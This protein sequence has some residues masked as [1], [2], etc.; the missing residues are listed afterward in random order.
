MQSLENI[1]FKLLKREMLLNT[2]AILIEQLQ[3]LNITLRKYDAI[4]E[5][6]IYMN[7]FIFEKEFI[8][9]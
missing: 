5:Y 7:S 3:S 6:T 1:I 8:K 4:Y 2:R 9:K